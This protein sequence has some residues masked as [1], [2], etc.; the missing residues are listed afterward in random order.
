MIE[1]KLHPN[2]DFEKVLTKAS[3]MGSINGDIA[4]VIPEIHIPDGNILVWCSPKTF[5][6]LEKITREQK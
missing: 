2:I 4:W 1:I 6:D 3:N 5:S